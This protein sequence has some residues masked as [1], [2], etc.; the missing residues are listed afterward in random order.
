MALSRSGSQQVV[1]L[2]EQMKPLEPPDLILLRLISE[3][4]HRLMA[5]MSALLKYQTALALRAGA[6]AH[7][8]LSAYLGNSFDRA[9]TKTD[10]EHGKINPPQLEV[11]QRHVWKIGP[12]EAGPH[13][14][15]LVESIR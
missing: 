5:P 3:F 1:L 11:V 2:K 8:P 13:A 7:G 14:E 6:V 4:Q 10:A 15:V 9:L 12:M